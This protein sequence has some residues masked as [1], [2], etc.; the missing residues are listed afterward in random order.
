MSEDFW[1]IDD[2]MV[3][4]LP[5]FG[6]TQGKSRVDGKRVLSGINK[7]KMSG[8]QLSDAPAE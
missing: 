7:L 6:K 5:F 3:P 1:F 2:Q 4:L 8:L